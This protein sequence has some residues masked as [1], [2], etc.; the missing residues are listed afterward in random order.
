MREIC[1]IVFGLV[2]GLCV[3]AE[4]NRPLAPPPGAVCIPGWFTGGTVYCFIS[5]EDLPLRAS[6]YDPAEGG[7]NCMDPCT[8]TATG[9]T[10]ESC[11]LRCIACPFEWLMWPPVTLVV[12]SNRAGGGGEWVCQDTGGAIDGVQ[13]GRTYDPGRGF[14]HE[15]YITIDF[16]SPSQPTWSYELMNWRFKDE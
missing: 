6:W 4:P 7:I 1:L 3:T 15:F 14:V 13:Y 8:L 11:Y 5:A 10:V 16:M 9:A 12:E 2:Q